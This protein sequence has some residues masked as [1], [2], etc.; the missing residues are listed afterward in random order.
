D[1]EDCDK[2]GDT[3][4]HQAACRGHLRTVSLLLERGANVNAIN[5]VHYTPLNTVVRFGYIDIIRLLV[6]RG[7]ALETRD[8]DGR[9]ALYLAVHCGQESVIELLLDLGSD[10]RT[11]ADDGTTLLDTVGRDSSL[12]RDA[13]R[14]AR[15]REMLLRAGCTEETGRG[16]LENGVQPEDTTEGA[17][18]S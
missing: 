10:P 15:I 13:E 4:L 9:T 1:I 3:S 2:Y 5:N 11:R 14:D 6:D 16:P 8:E 17:E 18:S 12:S 7:A